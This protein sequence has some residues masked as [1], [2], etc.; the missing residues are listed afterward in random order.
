MG[1]HMK[2]LAKMR[3]NPRSDWTISDVETLCRAFGIGCAA[4]RSGSSHYKVYHPASPEI[5]T[6]PFK[7]PIKA[8]YIRKLVAF[9]YYGA[10]ATRKLVANTAKRAE[11]LLTY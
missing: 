2:L 1:S 7:R 9:R 8:V 11:S 5:L 3:Q 6:I 10:N 4:S